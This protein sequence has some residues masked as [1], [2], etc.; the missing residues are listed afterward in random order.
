MSSGS[1]PQAVRYDA[2]INLKPYT[3]LVEYLESKAFA[4]FGCHTSQRTHVPELRAWL[5][6]N[7]LLGHDTLSR[8]RPERSLPRA[9]GYEGNGNHAAG[10]VHWI[11][12]IALRRPPAFSLHL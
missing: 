5:A 11:S 12:F 4:S 10:E 9:A 7:S 8:D 2:G 1:H 6:L 3:R